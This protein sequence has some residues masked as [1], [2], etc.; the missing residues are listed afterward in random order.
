MLRF[1]VATTAAAAANVAVPRLE[2]ND[3]VARDATPIE[4]LVP[5]EPER[6]V[7]VELDVNGVKHTVTVPAGLL[8]NTTA[9]SE[10]LETQL[11]TLS[12]DPSTWIGEGCASARCVTAVV[13]AE[14]RRRTRPRPTLRYLRVSKTASCVLFEALGDARRRDPATCGLEL[15]LSGHHEVTRDDVPQNDPVF[16]TLRDPC[17]RLASLYDHLRRSSPPGHAIH[18][19]R[20]AAAWGNHLLSSG[21]S[22]E[23]W[24]PP[25]FT[26]PQ[27]DYVESGQGGAEAEIACLPTLRRDV[28]YPCCACA[29]LSPRRARDRQ[30]GVRPTTGASTAPHRRR[31]RRRRNDIPGRHRPLAT[32]L[33]PRKERSRFVSHK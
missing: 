19:F 9:S 28:T 15:W 29:G 2:A 5:P 32:S 6:S 16:V 22:I 1:L 31:L 33:C 4:G 3:S 8:E 12:D 25:G 21:E 23:A 10:V 24:G 17:E 18:S 13:L 30:P 7:S 26:R 11:S 14:L 20:N 27:R